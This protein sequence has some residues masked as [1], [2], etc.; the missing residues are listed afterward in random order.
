MGEKKEV[1]LI[2][3]NSFLFISQKQK[4]IP[5]K[6]KQLNRIITN[7]ETSGLQYIKPFLLSFFF[8]LSGSSWCYEERHCGKYL[9][10][11]KTPG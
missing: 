6:I 8:S 3:L 11:F 2:D 5:F 10:S 9:S 7:T 4:S 1:L